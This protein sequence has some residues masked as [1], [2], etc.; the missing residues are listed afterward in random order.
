M[1]KSVI[2]ENQAAVWSCQYSV[3]SIHRKPSSTAR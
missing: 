1:L 2:H 3:Q